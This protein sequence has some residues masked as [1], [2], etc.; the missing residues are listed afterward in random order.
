MPNYQLPSEELLNL[1]SRFMKRS[2]FV[3]GHWIWDGAKNKKTRHGLVSINGKLVYLHRFIFC[4]SN[5]LDYNDNFFA[6]HK[7]ECNIPN[8]WNPSHIYKGDGSSNIKDIVNLGYHKE[9]IKTH[10]PRGHILYHKAK[11]GKRICIECNRLR[12]K[13]RKRYTKNGRRFTIPG[14]RKI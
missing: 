9:A 6:C 1:V 5:N 2:R 11:N 10:C 12:D 4:L 13:N 8:C 3:D 14:T 7:P